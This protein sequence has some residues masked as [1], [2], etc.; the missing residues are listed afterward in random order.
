MRDRLGPGARGVHIRDL[1][2][3][4]DREGGRGQ[5]FGGYVHVFSGGGG[6]GCEEDGLGEGPFFELG[7]DFV[8]ESTHCERWQFLLG[9]AK[10]NVEK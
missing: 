6:G 3:R 1:V 8:V 5:A 2:R 10:L 7:G 4:E 9:I